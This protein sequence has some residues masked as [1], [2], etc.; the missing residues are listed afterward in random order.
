VTEVRSR[1]ADA[2]RN[3]RLIV[4]AAEAEVA[5]T[6]ANASLE[7]IARDAGVGSATLHR[8][9]PSRQALLEAVFHDRVE[10]LCVRA[11][12]LAATAE[13]GAAL[14]EWLR[15]VTVYG[16]TTRGLAASMLAATR[17]PAP[18]PVDPAGRCE[19]ML[20]DAGAGL[21]RRAQESGAVRPE[22][23]IDDLLMLVNA[24]SLVTEDGAA[25]ARFITLA[26]DG[27]RTA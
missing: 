27:I 9:F 14:A 7:K 15:A 10:V 5:R 17:E 1:R 11:G 6:G 18:P 23:A 24:V 25:A 4:E 3:Y 22:V 2:Q 13:P 26:I 12:E 8:H 21:L 19:V 16:A 20:R